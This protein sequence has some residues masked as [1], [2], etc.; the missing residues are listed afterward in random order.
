MS[1]S[2][3][4]S[5]VLSDVVPGGIVRD[6][7]LVAGGAVVTGVAAQVMIPLPFTPVPLTLQTFAVVLTVAV[8]GLW[9][10]LASTGL[11]VVVGAAGV[12]W[13]ASVTSGVGSASFGYVLG[14]LL[15]AFVI[16][17][18]AQRGGTGTL[19]RSAGL[20]VLGHL[21]IYAVG[22]FWLMV[23]AHDGPGTAV[24]LGVLPFLFG[25]ALKIAAATGAL[26]ATW[27]LISRKQDRNSYETKS[28]AL[29]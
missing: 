7:A 15:A 23:A 22:V 9:R 12:P 21:A 3:P 20:M 11:Y 17:G 18:L 6:V 1:I 19:V 16:G 24:V 27:R 2:I 8:L 4:S 5:R 14:F 10:G 29:V 13:F 25:D 28:H 26:P